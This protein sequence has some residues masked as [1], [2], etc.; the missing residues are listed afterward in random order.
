MNN[1][2][3]HTEGKKLNAFF[4]FVSGVAILYAGNYITDVSGSAI[5]RAIGSGLGVGGDLLIL[6]SIYRGIKFMWLKVR[7]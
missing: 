4:I 1:K 7:K 5:F 3:L 6:Y 2:N